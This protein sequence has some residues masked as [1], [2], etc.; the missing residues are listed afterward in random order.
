MEPKEKLEPV[1]VC[2]KCRSEVGRG[3]SHVCTE[4]QGVKNLTKQACELGR[5]FG[6]TESAAYQRVATNLIKVAETEGE[7]ARGE[8]FSMATGNLH[9][10]SVCKRETNFFSHNRVCS[11]ICPSVGTALFLMGRDK[12]AWHVH[13]LVILDVSSL[14]TQSIWRRLIK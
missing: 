11:S 4:A 12:M 6:K 1:L 8:K 2:R 9:R 3:R 7:V 5:N 14:T 10:F 13:E